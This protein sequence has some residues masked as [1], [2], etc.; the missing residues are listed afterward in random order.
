MECPIC[1]EEKICFKV[2]QCD[3][4][5]CENCVEDLAGGKVAA[6]ASRRVDLKPLADGD[7]P[8]EPQ[9]T[10]VSSD[11]APCSIECPKCRRVT[12]LD[13]G[14]IGQLPTKYFG[15]LLCSQC[16]EK[17]SIDEFRW[18]HTCSA[19]ICSRCYIDKH[20]KTSSDGQILGLHQVTKWDSEYPAVRFCLE[21]LRLETEGAHEAAA[22]AKE[23]V[24]SY[25]E[26]LQ[27]YLYVEIE[28]KTKACE[29]DYRQKMGTLS[30]A[31]GI[32]LRT[33]QPAKTL[34]RSYQSMIAPLYEL[35]ARKVRPANFQKQKYKINSVPYK[36]L[37]RHL[38]GTEKIPG[39]ASADFQ[40]FDPS[41]ISRKLSGESI[42]IG[43]NFVKQPS[44]ICL[45]PSMEGESSRMVVITDFEHGIFLFKT[46]T[47]QLQGPL[48]L[49]QTY[50]K[51]ARV[52]ALGSPLG[53][54]P[55]ATGLAD[56]T[57]AAARSKSTTVMV[58]CQGPQG[59]AWVCI[60]LEIH[61]DGGKHEHLSIKNTYHLPL[62]GNENLHIVSSKRSLFGL[63]ASPSQTLFRFSGT[64]APSW[65]GLYSVAPD[66]NPKPYCRIGP[67]CDYTDHTEVLITNGGWQSVDVIRLAWPDDRLW[68][69]QRVELASLISD[70]KSLS[71]P[72]AEPA[73]FP[74][75]HSEGAD[76]MVLIDKKQPCIY[77]FERSSKRG[78]EL[79]CF[80]DKVPQKVLFT[81]S[82]S[83]M[84]IVQ[85]KD[86][87]Q[88]RS[89]E[90][91]V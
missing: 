11:K 29:N 27:E 26:G 70:S 53:K 68:S 47:L 66:R 77:A 38:L 51:F 89:L 87:Q 60:L 8:S 48:P 75:T 42:I 2:L 45:L 86:T 52:A 61:A 85:H 81:D 36:D 88:A 24:K 91:Y 25:L 69:V 16:D 80:N 30:E 63:S 13:N 64:E 3:H 35:S 78:F 15:Q 57:F 44:D 82:N 72:L 65:K 50:A 32:D 9:P 43:A 28:Q 18:C 67:I 79:A 5:F 1:F 33:V 39:L 90:F 73:L 40:F 41:H 59:S 76:R 46:R 83:I 31:Y 34:N 22:K 7:A 17:K 19:S 74:C 37:A 14:R 23:Y 58:T 62:P 21:Q 84:L 71:L 6:A 12:Q 20:V 55:S 54:E 10:Q 4:A 49:K 56:P